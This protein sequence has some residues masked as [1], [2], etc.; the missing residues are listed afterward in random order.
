MHWAEA[1]ELALELMGNHGLLRAGWGFAFDNAQQRFGQCNFRTQMITISA[2][3]TSLNEEV[4]VRDTIL[5]EIAHALTP[6]QGH[7]IKWK[8][9]AQEIGANPKRCYDSAKVAKP[10]APLVANCPTCGKE[11]DRHRMP[12]GRRY[13]KPCKRRFGRFDERSILTFKRRL[14]V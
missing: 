8:L 10:A 3:L 5:H 13:C 11:Y 6:G 4:V 14:F 9:K 12:R 1:E 2:P 7:N